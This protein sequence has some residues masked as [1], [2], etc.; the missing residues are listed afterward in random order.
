M[1]VEH[2]SG[3]V[4]SVPEGNEYTQDIFN[5]RV[6]PHLRELAGASVFV[7]VNGKISE[8]NDEGHITSTQSSDER[9]FGVEATVTG[10]W[11][12]EAYRKA[13]IVERVTSP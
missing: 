5:A 8:R 9:T 1:P 11:Y 2:K 3:L 13:G 7:P 12:D 4:I 10:Q 6:V